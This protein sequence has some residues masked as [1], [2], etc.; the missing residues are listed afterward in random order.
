MKKYL[1]A[2]AVLAAVAAP[3]AQAKT[4]Q[5]LRSESINS[6]VQGATSGGSLSQQQARTICT[7]TFDKTGQ[8]YGRR[9]KAT[10]D[11]IDRTGTTT[12]Q[13]RERMDRNI[14]VCVRQVLNY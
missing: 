14:E 3:A 11:T 1:F 5:Q 2:A 6:C 7:C 13:F 4:L 10:L 12:P 9:W 8:Q